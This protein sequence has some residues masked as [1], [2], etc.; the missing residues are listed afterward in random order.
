MSSPKISESCDL[1]VLP[2]PNQSNWFA[3]VDWYLNWQLC[4]GLAHAG[5]SLPIQIY[6]LA[7]EN[8][9]KLD[10]DRPGSDAPLMVL[11]L[12]RVPAEK[13]VVLAFGKSLSDWIENLHLMA[14]RLQVKNVRVFLPI[15]HTSEQAIKVWN[16]Q[17][18]DI[19][20]KFLTDEEAAL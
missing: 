18:G 12:G 17:P 2:A 7:E 15:G 16:T 1:W 10:T 20:A 3:R 8:A 14:G 11:S 5:I 6:K 9:V 13:C 4:K 19:Q